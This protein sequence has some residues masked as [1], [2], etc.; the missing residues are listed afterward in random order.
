MKIL[1]RIIILLAVFAASLFFM[2]RNIK[3]E[4]YVAN[5][6]TITMKKAIFP[7]AEIGSGG[8]RLNALHGYASNLDADELRETMTP[9]DKDKSFELYITENECRVTRIKYEISTV[10]TGNLV[11][12]DTINAM[13]EE[14][15]RKKA[16]IKINADLDQGKEY[17]AKLTLVTSEGRKIYYYTRIKYYE[18]QSYLKEKLEFAAMIHEAAIQKKSENTLAAYLEPDNTMNNTSL[19]YVTI[20]SNLDTFTWG[21]LKPEVL[22]EVIPSVKEFNIETAAIELSYYIKAAAGAAQP[23]IYQVKEFFRIR[24][25]DSRIYL[26]NYQRTM[27]AEFDINLISLKKSELKLGI[28]N[29]R[30]MKT[31]TSP[32]KSRLAFVRERALWYY[33]LTE[34]QAVEVFSFLDSA[35]PDYVRE[36]YDQHGIQILSMAY[37]GDMDFL[38]YGYMNRGDY[39]GRSGILLYKFYASEKRIEEQVYIPLEIPYQILKED[40]QDFNYVNQKGVFFF[41][42]GHTIYSYNIAAERLTT[43]ATDIGSDNSI[44]LRD[45]KYM[46][47]QDSSVP[48]QSKTI[49]LLDLE[50]EEEKII[51]AP[52]GNNIKILGSI[53]QNIIIGYAKTSDITE[54]ADGTII[55]PMHRIEIVD[56]AGSIRKTYKGGKAY[57]TG[58]KTDKN[59]ITLE[60]VVKKKNNGIVYYQPTKQD[61]IINNVISNIETISITERVTKKAMTELYLALP[62]DYKPSEKPKQDHTLSTIIT[63][64]TTLHLD[65]EED[66]EERY[67]VYALGRITGVYGNAADAI[68]DADE[69][70]G[71]VIDRYHYI[72]WERGGKYNRKMLETINPVPVSSN[73]DSIGACISMLLDYNQIKIAA[74]RLSGSKESMLRKLDNSLG[75]QPVNLTGCTLDEILYFV[76]GG[77]PVIAMKSMT[78][79][80]LITGYNENYV[81]Y[82][83]PSSAGKTQEPLASAAKTFGDAGNVF[84]SYME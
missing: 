4:N 5:M 57:V 70:M 63:K 79:A 40:I 51:E 11:E 15:G 67:Y 34:N 84:V 24:Y 37:N 82:Y 10:G 30:N 1:Y 3:E 7:V 6:E 61:H 41:S 54:M 18:E 76:S 19:S 71:V 32:D 25:T 66:S 26:L 22:T 59:I 39:E 47:W 77:R 81:M 9:L 74:D 56:R 35:Q 21:S 28:S 83:D 36:G 16:L 33:N 48:D 75:K 12:S 42:V 2:G 14:N 20:H 31:V 29:D 49:T 23:E 73:V 17:A 53:D 38:V 8:F 60:R 50:S 64:E 78:Q 68:R 65:M 55:E 52:A 45:D 62:S 27:E 44:M 72:V 46:A 69:K 80:V 58:I 43:L 13:E